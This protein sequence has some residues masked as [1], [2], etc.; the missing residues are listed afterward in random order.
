MKQFLLSDKQKAKAFVETNSFDMFIMALICVNSVVLG[1]L[2]IPSYALNFGPLLYL[3]DR[4]CLAIFLVEIG[5]KLFVYGKNFFA[6]RWN[7]FDFCI[8][9]LSCFSFA[10]PFIIFRA[11][12]LFRLLK[13]IN[14][15]SKLKRIIDVSLSLIPNFVAFVLVFGVVLYVSAII[16]VNMFGARFFNFATLSEST[17]TLLQVFTLDGWAHITRTVMAVYPH[18]WIFFILYLGTT[19]MLFLSFLLSLVD[20]LIKKEISTESKPLSKP[21]KAPA[22]KKTTAKK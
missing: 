13:Y 9:A 5:L 10:S 2:A 7:T 12:R 18:S 15:F 22:K 11:F 17:L 8:V 6:S 19:I 1:L 16:S 3:T 4:L 21:L 14:R 20:E